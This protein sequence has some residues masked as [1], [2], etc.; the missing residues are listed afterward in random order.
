MYLNRRCS[1][2]QLN[3]DKMLKPLVGPEFDAKT[4]IDK[5]LGEDGI[6]KFR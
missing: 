5:A 2:I 1:A 6:L 4:I 3:V